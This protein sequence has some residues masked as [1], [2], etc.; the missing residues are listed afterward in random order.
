[1]DRRTV[2]AF[3]LIGVIIVL[4]PYYMRWLQ[5]EPLSPPQEAVDNVES[6]TLETDR[7]EQRLERAWTDTVTREPGLP[8]SIQAPAAEEARSSSPAFV[9]TQ[10]VV[11]TDVFRAVFTTEGGRILSCRLKSY[12]DQGGDWLEVV[13]PGGSGLGLSFGGESVDALEFV[14][15]QT[16]LALQGAEQGELVFRGRTPFGLVE[17]KLRFQGNR[18]RMEMDLTT[19]GLPRGGRIGVKWT[20]ALADTEGSNG[21]GGGMY[22]VAYD[23]VKTFSGGVSEDWDIEALSDED[24]NPPSGQVTWVGVRNKYFLAAL[25]P[26]EG[27]YD[28]EL[29]GMENGGV[30]H[31]DAQIVADAS[32]DALSISC[33]VGPISYGVLRAQNR[34]LFGQERELQLDEFIDYGW[35][36]FR[37]IMKPMTI[38]ILKAFLAIHHLVP[39]FGVVI[40]IFSLLV[41]IVVFPLTHK[42]LE[43]AARMQQLQ[44]QIAALREKHGNDSQKVNTAMM[45][46]YKDQKVNPLGGCLPMVLQM[47]ILIALFTLFRSTI[48]LRQA[49]FVLWIDDLSQPDRLLVGGFEMHVLPLLMGLSMFIQQKMTMKDP[50]QAALVYIMP[51]FLTYIFWSMSSGLVFYYTLFNVLT[52]AQQQIME[53]TKAILGTK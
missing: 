2:L 14:P 26:Q 10:V 24:R 23:M 40:V 6:P 32:V 9:P 21:A 49:G 7:G 53:R 30:R 45:K 17:K 44:P 12:R 34:D 33:F 25:I 47:P 15:N 51:V 16:H 20:G 43:S 5:G 31:Y 19:S 38:V 1:M 39:N 4:M 13:A 42:S 35:E 37:P 3:V 29:S 11:E 46:L 28:V 27:Q 52:L 22:S 36:F 8:Q 48:E 41:K 50:K 18:Y